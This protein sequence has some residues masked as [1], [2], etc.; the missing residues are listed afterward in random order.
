MSLPRLANTSL[1]VFVKKDLVY[2]HQQKTLLCRSL[3]N[4]KVLISAFSLANLKNQGNFLVR[5]KP[6]QVAQ[7][8]YTPAVPKST[9][10]TQ[11]IASDPSVCWVESIH[12]TDAARDIEDFLMEHQIP[13]E[14]LPEVLRI[15]QCDEEYK[16]WRRHNGFIYDCLPKEIK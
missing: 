8:I 1:R 7:Y 4:Q 12:P 6:V 3:P 11:W 14:N 16:E 9:K 2:I 10:Y 5:P 13:T 15:F